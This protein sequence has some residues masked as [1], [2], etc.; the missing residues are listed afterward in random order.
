MRG[1]A[2][3]PLF[4]FAIAACSDVTVGGEAPELLTLNIVGG[5]G[6]A[7]F[8]GQTLGAPI[9]VRVEKIQG[10]KTVPASGVL[11]NFVV[12]QGGGSVYA[13]AGLTDD[14][15][16]ASDWWTLGPNE[17]PNA[18]EVRAVHGAAGVKEVYGTFTATAMDTQGPVVGGLYASPVIAAPGDPV[19]IHAA[20][21]ET[22]TGGSAV[23]SAEY[24][25]DGGAWSP[26]PPVDGAFDQPAEDVETTLTAQG[27][28]GD[29]ISVCVRG[30]DVNGNVGSAQ[31]VTFSIDDALGPATTNLFALPHYGADGT[32]VTLS[33]DIDDGSTG[34]ALISSA[35]YLLN[36]G[37]WLGMTAADGAFDETME[38]VEAS[39]VAS[40][41]VGTNIAFCVRGIDALSNIGG[42]ACA[43]FSIIDPNASLI[44]YLISSTSV[45]L[46]WGQI[47]GATVYR[48][49]TSA[50]GQGQ[51]EVVVNVPAPTNTFIHDDTSTAF[52]GSGIWDYR[53]LALDASGSTLATSDVATVT[54]P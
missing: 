52:H 43:F 34:G 35:E 12:T 30:S 16:V 3:L 31:C 20:I 5:N 50:T 4:A 18:L 17:G 42:P 41:A 1:V 49:E 7:G 9:V 45:G 8:P 6:Q 21:D 23:A 53:V 11:V 40:G 48:V 33:A 2:L 13:G 46:E 28:Q 39:F 51:W 10:K 32:T 25:L 15:G 54:V 26:M 36:A 29:V 38:T 37:P 19:L 22:T 44:A 47:P 24:N 27:S 14:D